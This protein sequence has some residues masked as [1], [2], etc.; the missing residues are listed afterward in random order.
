M[1][2]RARLAGAILAW[3]LGLG[4]RTWRRRL[5]GVEQI[6]ELLAAR[7]RVVFAF[8]HGKY[9]PLFA[10]LRVPGA[11]VFTSRSLRGEVL[12]ELSRRF[13]YRAVTIPGHGALESMVGVLR[14]SAAVAI[15][16]D[17]PLGPFHAVKRG[18]VELASRT[19]AVVMPVSVAARPRKVFARR[20]DRMEIPRPFS[21]V[22]LAV[23]EP[24]EV[25][26]DLDASAVRAW[27]DRLAAALGA[28]DDRV[29]SLAETP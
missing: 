29:E 6:G 27:S 11:C 13:G 4:A 26:P 3:L 17:G 19:G 9:V 18:A 20:W 1:S 21:R 2:R 23:G 5:E 12:A 16:V 8:W 24:I 10:L 22:H 28:L 25:P 14:E 7:R 15:A